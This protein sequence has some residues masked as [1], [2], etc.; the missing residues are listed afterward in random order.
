MDIE[1]KRI[2]SENQIDS[3]IPERPANIEYNDFKYKTS[4]VDESLIACDD[5]RAPYNKIDVFKNK[6]CGRKI[7]IYCLQENEL[8]ITTMCPLRKCNNR[9]DSSNI[10]EFIKD[11]EERSKQPKLDRDLVHSYSVMQDELISASKQIF[12]KCNC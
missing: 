12:Q 5:C 3:K 1:E 7:Y 8:K 2:E 10:C 9:I 4:A 11:H 6:Y